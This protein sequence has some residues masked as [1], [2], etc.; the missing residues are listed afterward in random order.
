MWYGNAKALL[1][2]LNYY[3]L[4]IGRRLVHNLHVIFR[5]TTDCVINNY[6]RVN[7]IA[8]SYTYIHMLFWTKYFCVGMQQHINRVTCAQN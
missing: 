7:Y 4:W 3:A 6:V 8:S 5:A 2:G 1:T